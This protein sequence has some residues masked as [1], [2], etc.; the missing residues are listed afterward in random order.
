MLILKQGP[1]GARIVGIR[2]ELVFAIIVVNNI[3]SSHNLDCVVTCGLDGKHAVN[4][5]HY[6]GCAL[7]IRLPS[8]AEMQ[9][10]IITEMK[11]YLDDEFDVVLENDHYHLELQPKKGVNT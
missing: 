7:D 1:D 3:F 4:S 9:G 8:T 5:L 2:T 11:R 10:V 6:V